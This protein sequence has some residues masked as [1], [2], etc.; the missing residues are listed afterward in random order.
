MIKF[1]LLSVL[2]VLPG[3]CKDLIIPLGDSTQIPIQGN[4]VWIEKKSIIRVSAI[5]NQL[6]VTAIETGTSYLKNKNSLYLVQVI[7]PNEMDLYNKLS[8]IL[9]N[10]LGLKLNVN[11]SRVEIAGH[12]FRLKDW[13]YI[14][15]HMGNND[16]YVFKAKIAPELIPEVKAYFISQFRNRGLADQRI[17][18]ESEPEL[19]LN[20]KDP[21][22]QT[23]RTL[24]KKFGIPVSKDTTSLILEPIIKVQITVAEIDRAFIQRYG[25]ELGSP[26]KSEILPTNQIKSFEAELHMME[27]AGK[28]RLLASPNILCKSGKEADFWAGGEIPIKTVSRY[29]SDIV[30]KK[31]GVYLKVKPKADYLGRISVS[32]QTE[33][34]S[35]DSSLSVDGVPGITTNKVSS[36]FDLPETKIIALSGLLKEVDGNSYSGL[37]LLS[38]LPILGPLFSS[39]DFKEKR[40][41]LVIFVKPEVMTRET[42]INLITKPRHIQRL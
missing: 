11:Q 27:T 28:G 18:F 13:L 10:R 4:Q 3:L 6:K 2:F 37:P 29:S 20:P 36:F 41:E 30:W 14:A 32:L 38:Q 7:K 19:K 31:Y 16:E 23:Y 25:I 22:I 5:G 15:D 34:S 39:R 1:F 42:D 8:G 33:V 21:H 40:T 17:N 35:I 24:L 12:L 26:L 9:K